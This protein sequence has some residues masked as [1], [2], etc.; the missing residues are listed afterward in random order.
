MDLD[1][2]TQSVE[3]VKTDPE[4]ANQYNRQELAQHFAIKF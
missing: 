3:V 4:A 2:K 1:V